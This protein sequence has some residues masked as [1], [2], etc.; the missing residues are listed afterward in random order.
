MSKLK[1]TSDVPPFKMKV[2]NGRLVPA[3]PYDQER[4]ATFQKNHV[5]HVYV[6]RVQAHPLIRKWWAVLGKVIDTCKTPWTDK[7]A[8]SEALKLALGYCTPYRQ[9][10]GDWGSVPMSLTDIDENELENAFNGAMAI[11]EKMT[12]VDPLTLKAE[13]DDVGFDGPEETTETGTVEDGSPPTS[14]SQGV[15]PSP[16]LTEFAGNIFRAVRAGYATRFNYDDAVNTRSGGILCRASDS[17]KALGKKVIGW[18][19]QCGAGEISAE[20][21]QAQICGLLGCEPD[22]LEGKQS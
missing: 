16:V 19:N 18:A 2:E 10:N 12:G 22:A 1:V 8:A 20:T 17:D 21:L 14:S 6:V 11:L 15:A 7:K 4:L 13:S 5:F 3:T 9:I